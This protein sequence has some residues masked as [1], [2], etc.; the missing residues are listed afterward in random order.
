MTFDQWAEK[1]GFPVTSTQRPLWKK[2]WETA[3][4]QVVRSSAP[5]TAE[6]VFASNRIME[7]NVLAGLSMAK[8]MPLV[9]AIEGVH[10]VEST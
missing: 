2:C 10:G 8:L 9:R 4:A 5:L 7:A 6:Q 3:Q 1:Q